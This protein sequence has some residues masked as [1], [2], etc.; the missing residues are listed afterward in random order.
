M[1]YPP[2]ITEHEFIEAGIKKV[3]A[4][5]KSLTLSDED[6]IVE[7]FKVVLRSHYCVELEFEKT[8]VVVED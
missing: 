5:V 1:N 7:V 8:Q 3:L 6:D 2:P 4:A